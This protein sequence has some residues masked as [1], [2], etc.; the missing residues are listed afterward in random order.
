MLVFITVN[1]LKSAED[2]TI[3]CLSEFVPYLSSTFYC[4]DN[5]LVYQ[6]FFLQKIL[7]DMNII[8]DLENTYDN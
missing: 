3:T 4:G 1:V 5:H 8:T 6:N 7:N 2:T